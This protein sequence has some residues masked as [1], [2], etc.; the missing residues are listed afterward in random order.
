MEVIWNKVLGVSA[1]GAYAVIVGALCGYPVGA[2]II[3]D[4][5]ENHQI[6]ES[7]AKYLLTFTNHASPVFV[8][9]YLC[10]ICLKDQIPARTVFGIFA[11]SDLTI[12]LLFRFV[13]Y[14]N[15]IQFLSADKKKKDTRLK[16]IRSFSGCLHYE[17]V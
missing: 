6:S 14:R 10:H 4:L 3:S 13:V 1:A 2:K 8:R 12:M 9:T 5:Y 16:L 15:K 11:L 17:W 7:E